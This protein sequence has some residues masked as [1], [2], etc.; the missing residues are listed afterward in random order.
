VSLAEALR[1][2]LAAL[3]LLGGV[4]M[5]AAAAIGAR[6]LA[7]PLSRLHAVTKSETLGLALFLGGLVAAAPGWRLA[8]IALATWAAMALAGAAAG[9]FIAMRVRDEAE[10]A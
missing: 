1:L 4:G 8:A 3:L 2:A 10:D 9:H 5:M 6:R 7:D